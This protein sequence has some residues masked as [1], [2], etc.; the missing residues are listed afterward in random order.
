MSADWLAKTDAG[1][2]VHQRLGAYIAHSA[3]NARMKPSIRA[4]NMIYIIRDYS[5]MTTVL[6]MILLPFVLIPSTDAND[7]FDS[8]VIKHQAYLF[9]AQRL[10][11]AAHLVR[12]F[13]GYFVYR[14]V[15]LSR[16]A[17]IHSQELWSAP[18][19]QPSFLTS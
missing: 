18:C 4:V 7:V 2:E 14:H 13:H 6:A 10:F 5:P 11:L 12:T 15:G 19:K 3:L 1:L 17:N 9:W 8:I 16:V